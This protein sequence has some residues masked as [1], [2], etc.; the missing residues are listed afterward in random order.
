MILYS[1][2]AGVVMDGEDGMGYAMARKDRTAIAWPQRE[3][4]H[5]GSV[6]GAHLSDGELL[7]QVQAVPHHFHMLQ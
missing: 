7:H 2:A 6:Q 4:G 5:D 3:S 1:E